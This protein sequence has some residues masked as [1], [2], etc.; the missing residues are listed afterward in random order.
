MHTN[1]TWYKNYKNQVQLS[2]I[3]HG[4]L[5]IFFGLLAGFFLTFDMLQGIKIWPIIH[6]ELE[7]P[8]SVRGWRTAH[9]GGILNGVMIVAMALCISK[10]QLSA[11]ALKFTYWSFL[12]TG[13]GNTI[14]YWAANFSMNRG[15][16]V[17]ATPYG[18]GEIFGTISYIAGASVMLLTVIACFLVA[19]SAWQSS[20]HTY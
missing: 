12:L 16:S 5:V 15:L 4:A 17:Q 8:G 2:L 14:F 3:A 7:I 20:K 19:K 9:T 10:I 1:E 11:G 6:M 18:E 13:W